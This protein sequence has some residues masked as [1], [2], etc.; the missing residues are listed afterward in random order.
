MLR[1]VQ[2]GAGAKRPVVILFLVGSH[3]DAKIR[4]ALGSRPCVVADDTAGGT[5]NFSVLLHQAAGLAGDEDEQFEAV[6][7]CGYSL[8]VGHVRAFLKGLAMPLGVVAIDGTH[9]SLPPEPWQIEV[10]RGLK[11]RAEL[12]GALFVATHTQNT[13]VEHLA[14]PDKPFL[15]T[16]SVL[17]QVTGLP[18]AE[19]GPVG[20]PAYMALPDGTP[21]ARGFHLYSYSSAPCDGAAHGLQQTEVLPMVLERHV[22][23]LLEGL[24]EDDPPTIPQGT[25]GARAVRWSRAFLNRTDLER[26]GPNSSPEI[27][28]WLAPAARR[29]T[30]VEL[31]LA[32]GEWCAAFACA[33]A[34]AVSLPAEPVP[35]GYRAAGIEIEQDAEENGCF[36]SATLARDGWDPA[37]GDLVILTRAGA[38][39]E[40]HICRFV[41]WID[42]A[43]GR[44]ETIGGNESNAVRLSERLLSDPALRGFV[45]YPR[46]T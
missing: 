30:G 37:E 20:A 44:F 2:P 22:R 26:K 28:A 16:I 6:V 14:P 38:G 5:T 36:R 27:A 4:A 10:W 18:L 19:S 12:G 34:R 23:P 13:Y 25:L 7:L 29:E 40:R 32:S 15:S 9:A 45:E 31:R 3:M 39:W 8:G 21:P 42:R 33:A 17:C 35:H 11:A 24:V 41:R 1:L 43:A 46:E